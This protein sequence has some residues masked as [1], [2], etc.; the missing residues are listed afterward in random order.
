MNIAIVGSRNYPNQDDIFW[1]INS[2]PIE[3]VVVS[4]GARGVDSYAETFA[5]QRGMTVK[6][7]HA[8]WDKY[9]KS[10]GYRRNVDIVNYADKVVAFWDGKS[11]GTKHTIDIARKCGK[12][13]DIYKPNGGDLHD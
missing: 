3:D 12:P 4:G 2:L 5:R 11:K 8:D 10:A 13:V 9:G 6:V 1:Y 7:F